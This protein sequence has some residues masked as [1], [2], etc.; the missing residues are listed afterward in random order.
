MPNSIDNT[1][2]LNIC[3]KELLKCIRE[4]KLYKTGHF[5]W[6]NSARLNWIDT[7]YFFCHR[8]KMNSIVN[9]I[10]ILLSEKE[11]LK[12]VDYIIGL[13]LKGSIMLSYVRFLFPEK[14]CSYFPE[15]KN[16]Y[17]GYELNLFEKNDNGVDIK[18]IAVLTDV[19]HS[20][21]TVHT[22]IKEV[23]DKLKHEVV[24][25]VIT[26]IDA[27]ADGNI[28][29]IEGASEIHLFPI[30]RIKVF[31]CQ[32]GRESCKIY[33]EKLVYVYEYKEDQ[34]ESN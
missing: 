4:N 15:N 17:N 5:H 9:G 27:T 20:G 19:V 34:N 12:N 23:Y 7:S 13:G 25:N 16:E 31:D 14:V 10:N 28:A 30:T 8:D 32:G 18:S 24:F 26:I 3:N 29:E 2:G 6:K 22:F 21:D 11:E 33:T 1:N